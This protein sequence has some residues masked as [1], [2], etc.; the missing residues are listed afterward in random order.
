MG[1]K[2]LDRKLLELV[3]ALREKRVSPETLTP[4]LR[5]KIVLMLMREDST[6]PNRAISELIGVNDGQVCRIKR[7]CLGSTSWQVDEEMRHLVNL[8]WMKSSEFQRR[9]IVEGD[10]RGAWSILRETV[11]T[12]QSLG[13]VFEAPKKVALAHLIGDDMRGE[14]KR[15]FDEHGVPSLPEFLD[16]LHALSGNGN[17]NK[18][19]A[20]AIRLVAGHQPRDTSGGNR[21][22]EEPRPA[23]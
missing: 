4:R 3:K 23:G 6:I 9:C 1:Q 15:F 19:D 20:L 8:I 17:G 12:L 22:P 18:A 5:R 10:A 2:K 11:E 7:S 14:L 21:E 13:Y 16:Q